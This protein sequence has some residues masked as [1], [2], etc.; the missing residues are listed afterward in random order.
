TFA[1]GLATEGYIPVF[2]VYST[3][4]QRAFDQLIHDAAL[5]N[6]HVIIALDRAG[7]VANDGATHHGIFDTAFVSEIPNVTIHSPLTFDML[8]SAFDEAVNGSGVQVIRYPKSGDIDISGFK[9]GAGIA[10]KDFGDNPEAAII[11]YGRMIESAS[12][13]AENSEISTRV[14]A[15]TKLNP[16]DYDVISR[17]L[18]GANYIVFAEEGI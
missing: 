16:I 1:C 13:A 12:I 8:E 6:L 2:A 3:F 17:L 10:C 5:Q 4:A 7:L 14:I 9:I 15:L 18:N 11:T